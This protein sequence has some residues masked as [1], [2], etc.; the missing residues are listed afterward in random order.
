MFTQEYYFIIYFP[1]KYYYYLYFSVIIYFVLLI[2]SSFAQKL[3]INKFTVDSLSEIKAFDYRFIH[4]LNL[5]VVALNLLLFFL[6]YLIF[7]L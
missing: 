6:L 5:G 1:W 7:I 3:M 4:T 2:I